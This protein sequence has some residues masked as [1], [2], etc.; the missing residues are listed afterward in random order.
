MKIRFQILTLFLLC[1]L[2]GNGCNK[3]KLPADLPR[4]YPCKITIKDKEGNPMPT[5][6]VS[7]NPE[8]KGNRWGASGETNASGV[9]EI[10]TAGLYRGLSSGKYR[11][12]LTRLEHTK[13]GR[14]DDTGAEIVES[15][16]LI[17]DEYVHSAQTP[18]LF[19]M[20]TKAVTETFHLEK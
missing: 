19:E 6:I 4:L 5:V 20:G 9:A 8:D 14:F 1:F 7:V 12:T 11:V 13:T 3:Q 18:F 15:K 2:L 17:P 16:N 10:F